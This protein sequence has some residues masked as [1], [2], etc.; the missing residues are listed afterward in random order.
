MLNI[1]LTYDLAISLLG[2]RLREIKMYALQN[3]WFTNL[4]AA[5]FIIAEMQK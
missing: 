4:I 2:I 3:D 5:L 1:E